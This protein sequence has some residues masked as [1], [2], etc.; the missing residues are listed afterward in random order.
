MVTENESNSIDVIQWQALY[1]QARRLT[2]RLI[3]RTDAT[4]G[5][6]AVAVKVSDR[7]FLATAKHVIDNDHTI[8]VVIRDS[9]VSTVSDFTSRVL[10]DEVDVALLELAP[11]VARHFDFAPQTRIR[12]VLDTEDKLP[13]IVVGYPGQ[14]MRHGKRVPLNDDTDISIQEVTAFTFQSVTLPCSDWPKDGIY[15]P[16]VYERDLLVDFQ[17]EQ[18]LK[19]LGPHDAGTE[20]VSIGGD[21]PRPHGL[22][23]GG[24]WLAQVRESE[25]SGLW[26]SDVCLIGLQTSYHKESGWL[27]GVQIGTLLDLLPT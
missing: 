24:I 3:D 7:S 23:G 25:K 17:P 2:Y 4:G 13:I 11:S 18:Q 19:I 21:P 27:R 26:V 22:S 20:A 15:P 14:F 12:T 9:V 8:E 10:H 16:L 1:E 6:T 5:G